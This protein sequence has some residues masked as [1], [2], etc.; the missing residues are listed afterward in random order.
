MLFNI[1]HTL[2]QGI[3]QHAV[4]P[5]QHP[6]APKTRRDTPGIHG[7]REGRYAL[8]QCLYSSS[9]GW[10]VGDK[11]LKVSCFHTTLEPDKTCCVGG[12]VGR[13]L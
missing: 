2:G 7:R 1:H 11:A 8:G 9:S 10:V 6:K 12:R 3:K 4:L 5:L 13:V